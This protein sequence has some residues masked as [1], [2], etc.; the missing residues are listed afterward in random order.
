MRL[1]KTSLFALMVAAMASFVFAQKKSRSAKMLK[2]ATPCM[3]VLNLFTAANVPAMGP[4]EEPANLI[5]STEETS[6][7]PC[8]LCV[9]WDRS[10]LALR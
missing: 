6:G 1:V 5:N 7:R 4:D 3:D 10:R 2:S 8:A 9:W